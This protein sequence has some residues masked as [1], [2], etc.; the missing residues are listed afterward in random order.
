MHIVQY[1]KAKHSRHL[2][3]LGNG[4]RTWLT[5]YL[6]KHVLKD[7]ASP[8]IDGS[9]SQEPGTEHQNGLYPMAHLVEQ[10]PNSEVPAHFHRPPQFQMFVAGDGW[11]G[12]RKVSALTVQFAAPFTPY[13]PIKSG[14]SGLDYLTLRNRWDPGARWMPQFRAE[15]KTMCSAAPRSRFTEPVEKL[16]VDSLLALRHLSSIALLEES[17][18]LR[19]CL[20]RVPAGQEVA[21][22]DPAIGDGQF[23]IVTGG[24]GST[25]SDSTECLEVGEM[26]CIFVGPD[27]PCNTV[28]ASNGGLELVLMQ[29]PK[30]RR[31]PAR[32][33]IPAE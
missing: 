9:A 19:V 10:E 1:E 31:I 2:N 13:G 29:F 14:T 8:L 21:G 30:N 20:Y 17:D 16:S 15:L 33:P 26:S 3:T 6:G 22:P 7:R 27:D 24:S 28:T 25:Q 32:G 12:K 4:T 11:L 23:W 18:G 5:H